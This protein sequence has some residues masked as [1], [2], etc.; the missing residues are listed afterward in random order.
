MNKVFIRKIATSGLSNLVMAKAAA[1]LDATPKL[2]ALSPEAQ[3]ALLERMQ[4]LDF[5][6]AEEAVL[7]NL[8]PEQVEMFIRGDFHNIPKTSGANRFFVDKGTSS[9]GMTELMV[10][11][12]IYAAIRAEAAQ[13]A[14]V[15]RKL[16]PELSKMRILIVTDG[17]HTE[18]ALAHLQKELGCSIVRLEERGST[19]NFTVSSEALRGGFMETTGHLHALKDAVRGIWP[20][21]DIEPVRET[22][23]LGFKQKACIPINQN[24]FQAPKRGKGKFKKW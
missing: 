3:Q 1:E 21:M 4:G 17:R 12:D 9:L 23:C 6:C 19:K 2:N 14:Q 20:I 11:P 22:T 8:K 7:A 18:L 16:N 24:P 15:I 5:C 10:Q 13:V